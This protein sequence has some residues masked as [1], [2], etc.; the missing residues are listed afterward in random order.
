M[1]NR[2]LAPLFVL[3]WSSGYI[4]G[5][6]AVQVASP[7]PL[8]F[9]RFALASLACM[10]LVLRGGRW[11]GAPFRRL[12]VIGLLLQVTQFGGAYGAFSLGLPAGVSALVM[13]GLSPLVLTGLS[14]AGGQETGD[15]RLWGGLVLGLAGVVVGLIPELGSAHLGAGVALALVAMLGLSGGSVLQRRWSKDVD[16]VVSAAVQQVTAMVVMAPLLAVFGGRFDLGVKLIAS[17]GWLGVGM[18]LAALVTLVTLLSR[19]DASRVGALLLLVPAVTALAS[20]PTLGE[21]LHPLTFVGM[22]IAA[23]GVG[24]VLRREAPVAPRASP[25]SPGPLGP[26]SA[27][28]GQGGAICGRPATTR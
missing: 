27:A 16:P 26:I 5:A 10:P 15:R 7:I 24:A 4:V 21:P 17:V 22:A 6:L 14:I 25:V 2:L 11:R 12:A 28:P 18:G 8:L 19:L 1:P 3:L 23:A 13:L 9:T 20:A